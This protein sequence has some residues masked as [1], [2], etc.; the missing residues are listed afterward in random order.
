M[1][2]CPLS[3]RYCKIWTPAPG[4]GWGLSFGRHPARDRNRTEQ[5]HQEARGR[6]DGTRQVLRHG[7][8][9]SA[10]TP[11]ARFAGSRCSATAAAPQ[12]R[13]SREAQR[14]DALT[15]R[16]GETRQRR[17]CRMQDTGEEPGKRPHAPASRRSFPR[18]S[19]PC[20]L[21]HRLRPLPCPCPP[22]PRRAV[23]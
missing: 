19:H 14:E 11:P 18:P 8:N 4:S 9:G 13:Q 21:R 2:V 7:R 15:R 22:A 10:R 17:G 16:A 12:G 23:R 5:P 1:D 3:P 20:Q 6:I